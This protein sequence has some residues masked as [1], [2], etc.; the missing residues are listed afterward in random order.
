MNLVRYRRNWLLS[1]C[2]YS[3]GQQETMRLIKSIRLT[4]IV[5]L[6]ER[7]WALRAGHLPCALQVSK[8][9]SRESLVSGRTAWQ[10]TLWRGH[11]VYKTI[12]QPRLGLS[13]TLIPRELA[14]SF[15]YFD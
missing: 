9:V 4:A 14:D 10:S 8:I 15:C 12:W 6:I 2:A 11:H 3:N 13:A 1:A 7:T 5:R